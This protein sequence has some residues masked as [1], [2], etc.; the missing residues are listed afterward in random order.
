ME[1]MKNIGFVSLALGAL[2][3]MSLIIGCGKS[4]ND[5][6]TNPITQN[7]QS[8]TIR[9][10]PANGATGVTTDAAIGIKFSAPMDTLSVMSR[11][12]FTGG[13]SMQMWMDSMNHSGGGGHESHHT[14]PNRMLTLMDSLQLHGQFVW[15]EA[16]DSCSFIL[17]SLMMPGTAHMMI[18]DPGM[19]SGT[20]MKMTMDMDGTSEPMEF[21]FTTA[22]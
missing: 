22:P 12:Y 9:V 21:H 11:L 19:M 6:V 7:G 15:N 13:S 1:K 10:T 16:M 8:L 20:G 14:D 5:Q 3:L 2:L 17:D 18:M 4:D